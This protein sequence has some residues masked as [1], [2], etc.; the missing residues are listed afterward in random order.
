MEQQGTARPSRRHGA[1]CA[2]VFEPM[3]T[4]K[5]KVITITC[6]LASIYG[7][8]HKMRDLREGKESG[9]DYHYLFKDFL[10]RNFFF[11]PTESAKELGY[12]RGGIEKSIDKTIKAF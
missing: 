7:I 10:C 2:G 3:D 1:S 11:D 6:F 9:L 8:F 12:D 5:K 4:E